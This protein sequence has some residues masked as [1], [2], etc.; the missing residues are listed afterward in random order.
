MMI[1]TPTKYSIQ[2]INQNIRKNYCVKI[3]KNKIS[4]YNIKWRTLRKTT[5]KHF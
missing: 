1:T 3:S 4:T 5:Q 2:I